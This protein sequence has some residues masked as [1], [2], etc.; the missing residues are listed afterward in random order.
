MRILCL[1]E[2]G[3]NSQKTKKSLDSLIKKLPNIEFVFVDSPIRDDDNT[4]KWWSITRNNMLSIRKY[5]TV[6]KSLLNLQKIW[7]SDKYDGIFGFSQGSVLAQIFAYQIQEKII[8]VTHQPKFLILSN[9][10]K[11]SDEEFEQFYKKYLEI[12][13]ILIIGTR[14]FLIPIEICLSVVNYLKHP[15]IIF[16]DG[17]HYASSSIT[18]SWFLKKYFELIQTPNDNTK[19]SNNKQLTLNTTLN[20][21]PN[22]KH[23]T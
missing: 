2:Y 19:I 21:T 20:T 7:N 14:N 6:K 4:Y 22:T 8:S 9:T 11:I 13:T 5:D 3:T 17:G 1:H 10:Y 12:P 16:H 23:D 15:Y 18:I